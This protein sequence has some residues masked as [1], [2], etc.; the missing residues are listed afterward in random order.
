MLQH[1]VA[2]LG[3]AVLCAAWVLLQRWVG[4]GAPP[5]AGEQN[6]RGCGCGGC[7]RHASGEDS[8]ETM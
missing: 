3:L 4:K 5:A 7:G 2:I 8:A 1:V 6:H